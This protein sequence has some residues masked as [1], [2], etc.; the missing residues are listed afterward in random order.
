MMFNL[1]NVFVLPHSLDKKEREI[2]DLMIEMPV[3]KDQY[4]ILYRA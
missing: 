4:Q 1:K 2:P 3:K